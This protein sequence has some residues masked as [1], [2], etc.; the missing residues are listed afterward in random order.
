MLHPSSLR[1]ACISARVRFSNATFRCDQGAN[2]VVTKW[3]IPSPS[4]G[5]LENP[6]TAP[7]SGTRA[8]LTLNR[9]MEPDA[10]DITPTGRQPN[11]PEKEIE[12]APFDAHSKID[13]IVLNAPVADVIEAS[14]PS[15][16][17]Q[18]L[19]LRDFCKELAIGRR[20]SAVGADLRAAHRECERWKA[21]SRIQH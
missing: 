8:G 17:S 16:R 2:S 20:T 15:S 11:R 5:G 21:G 19:R 13:S 1:G 7:S 10:A 6:P 14:S 3:R 18:S 4:F 9:H 12:S